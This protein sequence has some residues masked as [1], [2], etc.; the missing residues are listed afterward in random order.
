[1]INMR[2]VKRLYS[3]DSKGKLRVWEA[4]AE[5]E[6]Y[7]TRSFLHGGKE[8]AFV[9]TRCIAKNVTKSNR[10]TA[11][12]QAILECDAKY[13]LK[14]QEDYYLTAEEA[15]NS[16]T[17]SKMLAHPLEKYASKLN[18][19]YYMDPK[20]DGIACNI[21]V[22]FGSKTVVARTRNGKDI[23]T[24]FYIRE[25]LKPFFLENPNIV[26]CGELYNHSFHD[27]FED[28]V[29]L[30]KRQKLTPQDEDNARNF[31]Q[32]HVYDYYDINNPAETFNDRATTLEFF[33]VNF[34][35]PTSNVIQVISRA[36]VRTQTE[37]DNFHWDTIEKGFEGTM[38]RTPDNIYAPGIRSTTLLKRKDF[39]DE[40]FEILDVLEGN[41]MWLGAAKKIIVQLP[42]GLTSEAGIRGNLEFAANML[43][44][45]SQ[46][47]GKMATVQYFGYTKDGKL[48]MGTMKSVRDYE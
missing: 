29:S 32:Y 33:N 45:K 27:N 8:T 43:K 25:K 3:K 48:R 24:T 6:Y 14:L 19:P 26:L 7:Y 41:G 34:F 12:E 47:I 36:L 10:T 46:V 13:N 23:P 28:L 40:E 22:D 15:L 5:K 44:N 18:F 42:S 1:M 21:Y 2:N 17:F 38:I 31:L 9:G 35:Y 4:Y 37:A 30:I 11:E 20:L 16:S 39:I